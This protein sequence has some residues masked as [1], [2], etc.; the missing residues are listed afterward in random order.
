MP[1]P[2]RWRHPQ[3]R[4][5]HD[6]VD[7][8]RDV[9]ESPLWQDRIFHA[10][11]VLYGI[12]SVVAL[13]KLIRI[14]CRVPEYGWTTQKV[15]H[16]L[17]FL[18]NGVWYDVFVLR[19]NVQL[20]EP[21]II[22]HVLLDMPGL[23]FFTTYALLVLF[24]AEIYYQARAMS[25]DGLRPTF[26]WINGVVYAI[27]VINVLWYKMGFCPNGPNYWRPH[28]HHVLP[29]RISVAIFQRLPIPAAAII[30]PKLALCSSPW[31]FCM[32]LKNSAHEEELTSQVKG[33]IRSW[34]NETINVLDVL[35]N[36]PDISMELVEGNV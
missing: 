33:W 20:V 4:I 21:E 19:R 11:A 5:F 26:Y 28:V 24:W 31:G 12:I 10:L 22:Q 9:N 30:A 8:W 29:P 35:F 34:D 6:A 18:V 16:F 1:R 7:W 36:F 3:D 32:I 23:A 27:Q 17:N 14:E 2:P 15:F 25:T 13:V